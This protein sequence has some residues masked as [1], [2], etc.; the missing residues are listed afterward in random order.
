MP[1]YKISQ[2]KPLLDGPTKLTAMRVPEPLM[3]ELKKLAKSKRLTFSKLALEALN[4]YV[5][6]ERSH[7]KK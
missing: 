6:W 1:K 2:N 5:T 4:D 7:S 3:K